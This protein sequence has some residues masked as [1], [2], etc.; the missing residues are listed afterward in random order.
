MKKQNY[1]R[2]LWLAATLLVGIFFLTAPARAGEDSINIHLS[3]RTFDAVLFDGDVSVSACENAPSSSIFTANAWCALQQVVAQNNW[4]VTSTWGQ[5]GVFLQSINQYDSAD[6]NY[7]LWYSNSEPGIT[8]LNIHEVSEGEKLLLTYGINPLKLSTGTNFPYINTSSTIQALYF[9]AFNWSWTPVATATTFSING[10]NFIDDDGVYELWTNTTTPY[11]I[12]A[13]ANGYIASEPLVITPQLSTTTINLQIV[14]ATATIYNGA[15][16]VSACENAPGSGIYDLN[17]YC[18]IEQAGTVNSWSWWGDNGFLDSLNQIANDFVNN[19]YWGWF[20]NLEYGQTALNKHLLQSNEAL[21]LAYGASPLKIFASTTTPALNTTTT[22]TL[23]EFGLD[24]GWNPVWLSAVSSTVVING[25]E[26]FLDSGVYEFLI[27]TTTPYD[28]YG[29]KD[30]YI[31]SPHISVVGQNA[32]VELP[33]E[34]PPPTPVVNYAVGGGVWLS[35]YLPDADKAADFLARL[36]KEDGSFASPMYTDWA[37]LSLAAQGKKTETIAKVKNYLLSDPE[38]IAGMNKV[39]DYARRAMALMSLG[40][41]PYNGVKTNYIQGLID[42]HDGQQFGDKNLVNDDIFALL[43]LLNTGYGVSDTVVTN[44]AKFILANQGANGS[45]MGV[46]L[47]AAA[48]QCLSGIKTMEGVPAALDRA[49]NYL[50]GQ[51]K[52]DGG[53]GNSFSTSWA[54]QAIVAVG[55]SPANWQKS[56]RTPGDSLYFKQ[57]SDGGLEDMNSDTN[58]RLWATSYAIPAALGKGWNELLVDFNRPIVLIESAATSNASTGFVGG[59]TP[60]LMEENDTATSTAI[61]T[62][63]VGA[64]PVV[65]PTLVVPVAVSAEE[66]A[67]LLATPVRAAVA[68]IKLSASASSVA[69]G[70]AGQVSAAN[71]EVLKS[72][73]QAAPTDVQPAEELLKKLPLDTPT[74]RAAKR[75]LAVGGGGGIVIGAYLLLRFLK[76]VV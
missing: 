55:E 20:G 27:T 43:V 49:V 54:M 63:T 31:D 38:A 39:S 22:V 2:G 74:R 40:I 33:A 46:D 76:N 71:E 65:Q 56:N 3:V 73:D 62:S 36:Q 52:D 57:M 34:N 53:F 70:A 7:W 58:T 10:Q 21:L 41:N 6:G 44:T 14:A 18:A 8:A 12:T 45:W 68:G 35:H 25:Q 16:T 13:T 47:T 28:I 66:E 69:G 48:V 60:E 32:P 17:G 11:S 9:D 15:L 61:I 24:A 23:Q 67:S 59:A 51:Q 72:G 75:A 37:A 30:G 29:K 42:A 50:R 19:I 1:S 5:L 26:Y 64:S 4:A